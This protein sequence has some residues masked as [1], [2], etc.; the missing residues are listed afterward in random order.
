[1]L[2]SV[3]KKKKKSAQRIIS[4]IEQTA[5]RGKKN[6]Q[7]NGAVSGKRNR[8]VLRAHGQGRQV[9]RGGVCV[10]VCVCVVCFIGGWWL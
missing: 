10:C 9:L 5:F 1:M 4:G 3:R 8:K 7:E 6:G 2:K